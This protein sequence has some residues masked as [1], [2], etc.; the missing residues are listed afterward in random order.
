MVPR[1]LNISVYE[2]NLNSLIIIT[3][4]SVT[5]AIFPGGGIYIAL[6]FN[7]PSFVLLDNLH[8][9]PHPFI[10]P[11]KGA[12]SLVTPR[13]GFCSLPHDSRKLLHFATKYLRR[14]V[15]S[16]VEIYSFVP[17]IEGVIA[18]LV[19]ICFSLSTI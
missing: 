19:E 7:F 17:S 13:I 2:K 9:K 5:V 11:L 16:G 8:L 1:Y 15:H 10:S 18:I 6:V 3:A 12:N 4:V 14:I